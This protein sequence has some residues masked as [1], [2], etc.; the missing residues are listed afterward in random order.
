MRTVDDISARTKPPDVTCT[1]VFAGCP[2]SVSAA[3]SW[4]AGFFPDPAAAADAALMTSEL[5]TNAIQY[6]ASGLPGGTFAVSVRVGDG[7]V[8]VDV[9]DQGELP[10][11]S[12]HAGLGKGL[13][14]VGQLADTFGIDGADRWFCLRTGGYAA[15]QDLAD[16][17][18]RQTFER[19]T[20]RACRGGL[21]LTAAR[22][23]D[24][25][26]WL[27]TVESPDVSERSRR[28]CRRESPRSPGVTTALAV[29]DDRRRTARR[30]PRAAARRPDRAVH[31][32]RAPGLPRQ[33]A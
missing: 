29:H 7:C 6:S 33:D 2:E 14:I 1:R 13:V 20:W 32:A 28:R 24:G 9:T 15:G 5:V 4:V 26:G 12:A 17:P 27:A 31:A 8:R 18:W 11:A 30:R 22:A 16:E 10:R 23:A 21:V 25:S 3:R 19:S